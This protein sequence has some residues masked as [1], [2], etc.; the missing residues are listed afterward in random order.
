[1]LMPDMRCVAKQRPLAY[2]GE[3]FARAESDAAKH[4]LPTEK[5]RVF[6]AYHLKPLL[7]SEYFSYKS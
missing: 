4:E 3:G 5:M 2:S 1:M 7:L 6:S